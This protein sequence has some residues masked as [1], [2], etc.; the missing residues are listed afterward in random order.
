[1]IITAAVY[2]DGGLE[3]AANDIGEAAVTYDFVTNMSEDQPVNRRVVFDLRWHAA[4]SVLDRL[5]RV[6]L[7]RTLGFAWL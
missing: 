2:L 5:C 6:E 7:G 3:R 4:Q 1:M